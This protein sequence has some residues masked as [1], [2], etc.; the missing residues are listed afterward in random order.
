MNAALAD[1]ADTV[2]HQNHEIQNHEIEDTLRR[3]HG[4]LLGFIRARVR[5]EEDAQDI[6]QDVFSR[7]VEAYRRLE[8]IDR[9]TAWLF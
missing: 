9:V 4:R 8:S 7:L 6:L 2:V 5:D 1:T 3:E